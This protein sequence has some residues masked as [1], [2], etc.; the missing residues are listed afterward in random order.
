M[1]I[2]FVLEVRS[3]VLNQADLDISWKRAQLRWF[4]PEVA[5]MAISAL[6]QRSVTCSALSHFKITE[7]QHTGIHAVSNNWKYQADRA[8]AS[9]NIFGKRC[10]L[11]VSRKMHFKKVFGRKFTLPRSMSILR[12]PEQAFLV[13]H[14]RLACGLSWDTDSQSA[15]GIQSQGLKAQGN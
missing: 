14:E 3:R 8:S 7:V 2:F 4:P 13:Q 6:I 12:I 11:H 15:S 10:V 1:W 5:K 9:R